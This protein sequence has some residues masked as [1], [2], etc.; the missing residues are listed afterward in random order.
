MGARVI[1]LSLDPGLRCSGMGLWKDGVLLHALMAQAQMGPRDIAG[2]LEMARQVEIA[3]TYAG[4]PAPEFLVYEKQQVY[5]GA[6]GDA[7][8][9]FQLAYCNG[10]IGHALGLPSKGYLPREWKGQVPKRV[11]HP[12]I[13]KALTD[14]ERDAYARDT[15]GYAKSLVHN[16][17]D[18][19]GLGLKYLQRM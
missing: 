6:G 1:I 15:A 14:E 8:D 17:T 13:I 16:V 2:A 5:P 4:A 19:V 3:L 12:R 7:D 10:A 9:L 18:A 11:H